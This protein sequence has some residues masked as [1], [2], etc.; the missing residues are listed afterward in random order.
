MAL[1][2]FKAKL[3]SGLRHFY[4]IHFG[5]I[6]VEIEIKPSGGGGGGY[7]PLDPI[8]IKVTVTYKDQQWVTVKENSYFAAFN[9][10][11]VKAVFEGYKKLMTEV[12]ASLSKINTII[13]QI[14]VKVKR[15]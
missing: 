2:H 10:V 1:N 8:Y 14:S 13:E 3:F 11:V 12:T 4:A 6:K 9:F 15:K 7:I 5:G